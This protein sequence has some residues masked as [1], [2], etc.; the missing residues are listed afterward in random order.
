PAPLALRIPVMAF[1]ILAGLISGG[2]GAIGAHAKTQDLELLRK[3]PNTFELVRLLSL[4]TGGVNARLANELTEDKLIRDRQAFYIMMVDLGVALAAAVFIFLSR[5]WIGGLL[6]LLAPIGPA[7]I[8]PRTLF[9]TFLFIPTA[10]S[11][12]F[13]WKRKGTR[14]RTKTKKLRR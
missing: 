13:V 5:G 9:A 1:A 2:C 6:L 8:L 10:V 7:I 14:P 11:C 12:F 4:E 3:D